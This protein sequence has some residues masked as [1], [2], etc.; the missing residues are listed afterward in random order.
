[1]LVIEYIKILNKFLRI[2]IYH[3]SY[4]YISDTGKKPRDNAFILILFF[5]CIFNYDCGLL[6]VERK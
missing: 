2:M 3:R 1:M 4:L 5:C 6:I